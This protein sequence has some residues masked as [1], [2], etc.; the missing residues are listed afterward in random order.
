[1]KKTLLGAGIAL[2]G[3]SLGAVIGR[4]GKQGP[5]GDQGFVGPVGAMG[6]TGM[7]GRSYDDRDE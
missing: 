3:V 5:K 7:P 1:M 6:M 4:A 2:V